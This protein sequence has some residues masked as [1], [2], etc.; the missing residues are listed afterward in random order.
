MKPLQDAIIDTRVDKS[1]DYQFY[2]LVA[3]ADPVIWQTKTQWR[4]FPIKDQSQS[5]QCVA[6]TLA[7]ML[8]IQHQVDEGDWID[9]SPTHIYERRAN[10]GGAGMNAIDAFGIVQKEGVTFEKLYP[11]KT[12]NNDH[13][14]LNI[15]NHYARVGEVFRIGSYLT[16]SR[17][18]DT[19]A[20]IIQ[21]TGKGVMVWFW[22][23]F[24][25]WNREVPEIRNREINLFTAP[26]RHSVTAVDFFIHNGKKAL[27]IEDSWGI[28]YGRDGRRIITEDFLKER[29]Y[30]AGHIMNFDFTVKKPEKTKYNITKPLQFGM[31][32]EQVKELQRM[33]QDEGHFPSNTQTTTYYGAI[34]ARAVLDW[35]LKHKVDTEQTLRELQGRFF[36]RRSLQ[37]LKN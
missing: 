17:D 26:V 29:C 5:N 7:K 27:L 8:G 30:Y 1:K 4:T 9:F 25:E 34:T 2:E 32:D 21:R 13:E 36:G 24:A 15:K 19:I 6:F 10:K 22:G 16:V 23:D 31:R 12:Y 18:I 20:S 11:S 3:K 28:K 33:L 35:Q 37:A 14:T